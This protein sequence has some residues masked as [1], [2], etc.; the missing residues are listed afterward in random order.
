MN[1]MN[2]RTDEVYHFMRKYKQKELMPRRAASELKPS[3]VR[4]LLNQ[5]QDVFVDTVLVSAGV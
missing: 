3:E 4:E 2:V 5:S 1:N